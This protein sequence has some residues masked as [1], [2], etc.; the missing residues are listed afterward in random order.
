MT[1]LSCESAI[2]PPS[3]EKGIAGRTKAIEAIRIFMLPPSPPKRNRISITSMLR[4]K[5]SLKAERNWHQNSG[6]NRRDVIRVRNITEASPRARLRRL[7]AK[8]AAASSVAYA[9]YCIR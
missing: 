6:A 1:A 9:A 8:P 2:S 5:L 7:D 3:A 4:T